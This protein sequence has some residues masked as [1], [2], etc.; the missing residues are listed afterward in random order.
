MNADKYQA[1]NNKWIGSG[2]PPAVS[3]EKDSVIQCVRLVMRAAVFRN[4]LKLYFFIFNIKT[5][6]KTLKKLLIQ[7][8]SNK[9]NKLRH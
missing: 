1:N 6:K 7:Y 4:I 3:E 5:I 2:S 9:E 8:F